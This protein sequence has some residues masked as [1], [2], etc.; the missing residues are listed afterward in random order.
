MTILSLVSM[1]YMIVSKTSMILEIYVSTFMN[2]SMSMMID[3]VSLTFITTVFFISSLVMIYSIEY[4]KGENE[5]KFMIIMMLFI[6]F[7]VILCLTGNFIWVMVGWD[8]LGVSSFALIM[9]FQ[10]WKSFNSAVVTFMYNRAGDLFILSSI[11]WMMSNS[12]MISWADSAPSFIQLMIVI[13]AMSKS[14]QIPFSSWLPLAM[15]APTPV[16]SLVHSST[17]VTAGVF[18]VIRFNSILESHML[19]LLMFISSIT[20]ILAGI[21]ALWE[22]DLKKIIALSTL[23]HIGLMMMM[24]SINDEWPAMLH[25][26]THSMFKS[27]LFMCAGSIIHMTSNVQDIRLINSVNY[28]SNSV[29][30]TS[31]MS[32]MGLPFLSGFYSKEM[33]LMSISSYNM[34]SF[35]SISF[36]LAVMLTCS[37]SIRLI[38]YLL[39]GNFNPY[40][41]VLS[42]G[43]F[44]QYPMIIGCMM[45]CLAGSM[46][47]WDV[48][49]VGLFNFNPTNGYLMKMLLI[50]F[51][52]MGVFL[53]SK[54]LMM[55]VGKQ[56][57]ML[58]SMMFVGSI[59]YIIQKSFLSS[60]VN[61]M[62][63][64]I[65]GWTDYL[66]SFNSKSAL[67][68]YKDKI[69]SLINQPILL[70]NL[71]VKVCLT[72]VLINIIMT[73]L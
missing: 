20:V 51:M 60:S 32:M 31:L 21:S 14:A 56:T 36:L 8:G 64:D 50:F 39:M 6:S 41:S 67:N 3:L 59:S 52:L 30:I 1:V 4:M 45:S 65:K 44:M 49:M 35:F 48:L 72:L 13:T 63:L 2:M 15:A 7:M 23:S 47:M 70:N 11:A 29:M 5:N 38:L 71:M 24:I 22:F 25:L 19:N 57:V 17:L 37:Y 66:V 46:M 55:N 34:T 18:L 42:E 12:S 9:Y 40:S 10:N 58:S 54:F 68:S 53:G 43:K 69:N 26:V 62:N 28:S 16:S 73:S 33:M 27:L 61:L